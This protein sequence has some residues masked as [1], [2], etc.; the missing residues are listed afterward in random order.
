MRHPRIVN[1]RE[2]EPTDKSPDGSGFHHQELSRRADTDRLG[3]S[4]YRLEPGAT[5]W[6]YHYHTANEEAI[7]VLEGTGTIHLAGEEREIEAGDF[8]GLPVG[9]DG[10]H[11]VENPGDADLR[12]LCVST[13]VEPDIAVYPEQNMVG[14]FAGAAPGR[15]PDERSLHRYL[16]ADA[17]VDYWSG[18]G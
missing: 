3:C 9:E 10:A 7:F 12:Y 13:M 6:P 5:S 15:T 16:R 18:E 2:V 11:R 4:I 1:E 17:E 8:V 14:L